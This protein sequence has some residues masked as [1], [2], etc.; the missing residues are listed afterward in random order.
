MT[1]I[2]D[3]HYLWDFWFAP[4]KSGEPYHLFYL[5]APRSLSDSDMRHAV[6][7]VG[8]ATST[9]LVH[10]EELPMALGPGPT[11]SWDDRAIWTGSIIERD[12]LYYL[13]YT[14]T[15][16]IEEG[17]IQRIGLAT[18]TNLLTWER[19]PINPLVEADIRW[20]EKH[21]SGDWIDEACRDPYVVFVPSENVYYMFFCARA[22]DGPPDSRGVIGCARSHDLLDWEMLPPVSE[23]GEFG[24][25]EVPQVIS[26]NNSLYM[27]F[28]TDFARHAAQRIQRTG[29]SGQWFGTH[30]L[31][32]ER[33]TGPY[34]L[35][36]DEGLVA[37]R[38]GQFYAGKIIEGPD[39]SLVFMAWHGL[40]ETGNFVGG[41]SNP[42]PVTQL[43]DGRLS[44]A[45][46]QLW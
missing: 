34:R 43:A 18:S 12:K 11:R 6:A 13:F 16:L 27:L 28:C 24:Y 31:C 46:E 19:C 40:D 25:L 21:D 35:L 45:T 32:A 39:G 38:H 3:D 26:L 20:Y 4:R 36:N 1:F 37:D 8:H 5:Q 14:G 15:S 2:P 29:P 7:T 9:D 17:L 42:A 44:V 30:Y 41:L 22:K 23:P 33:I 10:W